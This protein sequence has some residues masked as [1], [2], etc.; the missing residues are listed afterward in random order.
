MLTKVVYLIQLKNRKNSCR[1]PG[2]FSALGEEIR[3]RLL[4]AS[5]RLE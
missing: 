4:D 5:R 1:W 3:V 2:V